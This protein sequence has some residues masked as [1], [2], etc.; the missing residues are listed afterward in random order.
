M[1]RC[2][3]HFVGDLAITSH[4][5]LTHCVYG[6]LLLEHVY[7]LVPSTNPACLYFLII[8]SR[9]RPRRRDPLPH[10]RARPR[11][12]PP[13]LPRT[14]RGGPGNVSGSSLRCS[15][16]CLGISEPEPDPEL[17]AFPLSAEASF[18]GHDSTSSSSRS[19]AKSRW[20]C[21]WLWHTRT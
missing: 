1:R 18:S 12:E 15:A 20:C 9:L 19:R 3:L 11:T 4:H 21:R 14:C 5:T 6:T 2:L 8:I 7:I 10:A 17:G 13:T 16:G